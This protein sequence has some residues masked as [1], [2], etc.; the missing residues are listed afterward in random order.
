MVRG[1]GGGGSGG[2]GGDSG[3]VKRFKRGRR[4]GMQR[5]RAAEEGKLKDERGDY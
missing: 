1:G 4:K 5:R 2:R 3:E